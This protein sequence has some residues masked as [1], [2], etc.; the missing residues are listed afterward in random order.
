M[1]HGGDEVKILTAWRWQ[2]RERKIESNRA[3]W[4]NFKVHQ[5]INIISLIPIPIRPM[6]KTLFSRFF[7]LSCLQK[8]C[9]VHK[10][11]ITCIYIYK[12][13]YFLFSTHFRFDDFKSSYVLVA[14]GVVAWYFLSHRLY[15]T[16][17][18][19]LP[20]N[21]SELIMPDDSFATFT[22]FS[23]Q[24]GVFVFFSF[25]F[26]SKL[27]AKQFSVNLISVLAMY[28]ILCA[29][30]YMCV[31]WDDALPLMCCSLCAT[32]LLTLVWLLLLPL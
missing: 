15:S 2:D 32:I 12:C 8:F 19:Y 18:S 16:I 7:S 27:L 6:P 5:E 23:F 24:R 31:C 4:T 11:L 30:I 22:F 3:N 14:V 26:K 20:C 21:Y 9:A 28:Q 1:H 13:L 10:F 25:H 17:S 29:R